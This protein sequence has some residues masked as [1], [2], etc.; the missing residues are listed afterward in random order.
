MQIVAGLN[1]SNLHPRVWDPASIDHIPGVQAVMI[2]WADIAQRH[3]LRTRMQRDGIHRTLGI[4]EHVAMYLD[5]GS[6]ALSRN[7]RDHDPDGYLAFVQSVDL[8]WYPVPRD[9]IPHPAMEAEHQRASLT[10][11]MEQNML[12][13]TAEYGCVP[14]VHVSTLLREYIQSLFSKDRYWSTSH[15]AIGGIVPN[16]LRAPKARPYHDIFSDLAL[17]RRTFPPPATQLHLFGVG[18]TATLHIAALLGMD[19]V[20]SSGWRNR[21]A[22]GLI[23][24]P[25]T[26]DRMVAELGSWRGRAL[27]C[28]EEQQ[29]RECQC[30]SC[31][32]DGLAGLRARGLIGF[33]RRAVHNLWV[34]LQ[35]A[36]LVEQHLSAGTYDDWYRQHLDNSTYRPLIT[37]LVEQRARHA[38][39]T[40]F[41][42]ART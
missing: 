30:P 29:L 40:S 16:L 15:L 35:E 26:G 14:V 6:F 19:S 33:R 4:P 22:R 38:E 3:N 37:Y 41:G 31:L 8:A 20:D 13:A 39:P 28:A 23:Q 9:Y 42:G 2:S 12:Y 24:L 36:M 25:G 34:L 1:L 27:S 10:A 17:V 18:G 11:T 21:A 32:A 7:E 5:N